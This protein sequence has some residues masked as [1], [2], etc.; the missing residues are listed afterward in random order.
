MD[1]HN[2]TR[3]HTF[4]TI[5]GVEALINL[6]PG[7]LFLDLPANTP[8]YIRV[9]EGD[10]VQE[11]DVRTQ[12]S[13]T[14]DSQTLS[15]WRIDSISTDTVTGVDVDTGEAQEWDRE[16]LIQ[17]LGTGGFSVKL[18]DFDRV[19]VSE[20]TGLGG[21]HADDQDDEVSPHVIVTAYGNNGQKFIQLYSATEPGDWESL[22]LVDQD[23][24]VK[25]FSEDV[26]EKFE[27]AV[28]RAIQL[29]QQYH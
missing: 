24:H 5:D 19:S 21:S 20:T 22:Q 25:E 10:Q 14:M 12:T 1:D 17:R 28:A 29:E 11:G 26:L 7:E 4:H 16:W 23:Q 13:Q 2:P 3:K 6:D 9:Q 15:K 8:R 18:T 27:T